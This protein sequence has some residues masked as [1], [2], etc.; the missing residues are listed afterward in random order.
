MSN[1]TD[2]G[3][4]IYCFCWFRPTR[5]ILIQQLQEQSQARMQPTDLTNRSFRPDILEDDSSGFDK[6]ARSVLQGYSRPS[7]RPGPPECRS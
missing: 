6:A 7:G 3:N 1:S 4:G 2:T 5:T